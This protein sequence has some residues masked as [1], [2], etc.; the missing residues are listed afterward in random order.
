[1]TIGDKKTISV[2]VP[3][4]RVEKCLRRCLDS[5]VSQTYNNLE[6]ILVDDGS[7]DSCGEICDEYAALDNRIKVIHQENRGLCG[8]RN[9]GLEVAT[10]DYIGFADSDD[11]LAEDMYEYL[12]EN[13]EKYEADIVSCRYYRVT[14]GRVDEANLGRE[15]I[16]MNTDEAIR[17][18]VNR[19]FLRS[20]F[21]NKL[22]KKEVL[23][24][25]SFP[26][27]R[28]FEGTVS[29]HIVFERAE[30]I[31][32]L[33][34][35]K[36]YYYANEGSI[37]STKNLR[38]GLNYSLSYIDRFHYLRDKYPDLREK[39]IKDA[40]RPIR[41]LR[42]VCKDI[43]QKEI[44][45]NR[46]EF[47]KIRN[48]VLENEKII[49]TD[50]LKRKAEKAEVKQIISLTP[51]G[52][53]R[54][55]IIA[56]IDGRFEKYLFRFFRKKKKTD[57][58][59][60]KKKG[61]NSIIVP[62]M[63]PERAEILRRLQLSLMTILS[64]ID[65]ICRKNNL[66][67]FIYGGTLLGAVRNKGIIPWDDDLDIV[68]YREDFEKFAK[69]CQTQLPEGYFYQSCFNDPGYP[70]IAAKIR[71]DN[72]YICEEKWADRDFHKGIFVDILPLDYFPEN[73]YCGKLMINIVSFLNQVCAGQCYSTDKIRRLAF[74]AAKILPVK[75]RYSL[76]DKVLRFC[77]RHS[78]HKRVCSF[79]SHYMPM[80][81]R[82]LEAE[83]FGEG[84]ELE[85]EGMMCMAPEKWEGYLI[86]LFGENYPELPPQEQRVCHCNLDEIRFGDEDE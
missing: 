35:A 38:N 69:I 6:I 82:I 50:I 26:E 56:A 85:F 40:V 25:F 33:K 62:E 2:I 11:R 73:K 83:W 70:N 29:M 77:N 18:L 43:T 7:P 16:V 10:G 31:V 64:V 8:A 28:T 36:Y 19:F 5:I 74:K 86:H 60:N 39:M 68:M 21:W 47:E 59:D 17:E 78:S 13:L 49:F 72:T 75:I 80:T 55:H 23:E 71:K 63:T 76:R 20:T 57:S 51:E 66:K 53:S 32:M 37:I 41:V 45:D 27:G 61:S 46:E 52:F 30:K 42:Y 48:F 9:A 1:M 67:Y 15:D 58:D 79:G 22:F 14:E 44:N 54:A 4:Y 34:D 84:T 12:V 65:D 24:G 3:V 81:K